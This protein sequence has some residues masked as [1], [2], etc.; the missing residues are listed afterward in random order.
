MRKVF[1]TIGIS[2]LVSCSVDH[3]MNQISSKPDGSMDVT[4]AEGTTGALAKNTKQS[5]KEV[6][7]IDGNVYNTVTI[8]KQEWMTENLKTTRLNDG[9]AIPLIT[10]TN[11]GLWDTTPGKPGYCWF[12]NDSV[13]NAKT[14]GALYNWYAVNTGKLAP[15]GWHVPSDSEWE[16]LGN[17]L[18]GDSVAGGPLKDT[19]TTYW[20]S[21]NTGATN[22]SGFSALPGGWRDDYGEFNGIGYGGIGYEGWWWSATAAD[23]IH[24][25][26]RGIFC[27]SA[28]VYRGNRNL[29]HNPLRSDVYG[30]SVRC[31]KGNPTPV[32]PSITMQ[33]QSQTVTAGQNVKFSVTATGY[34]PL[35]YQWYIGSTSISGATASSYSITNVQ[36]GNAGTYTVT[37]SN[38]TLPN[39][40]SNRAVLTV[41]PAPPSITT[42]PQSQTAMPGQNVKFSVVATGT[43][44]LSYQWYKDSIAIPGATSSSYS[45]SK[46]Q[47]SNAGTYTVTVSNGILPN[48]KSNG[49]ILT[50]SAAQPTVTDIDGN[51]YQP[52]T[53]GTQVWMAENLKT[54]RLNDGTAIPLVTNGNTWGADTTPGTPE[55]CWYNN[56]SATTGYC[57]N[58]NPDSVI[59]ANPCGALYNWYAVNTGK[60]APKGWHVPSDSEWEVLG[61]YLGGDSVA[62][63]P[64]KDTGT[65][66]WASPNTGAT[67]TSGFSALPG[68]WRDDYGEFNGIGYGGIGY[69][70]WWWSATAADSIHSWYRGILNNKSFVYRGNRNLTH[71]PERSDVYGFSVRCVKN[72]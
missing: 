57:G 46:V 9:T 54:T 48:A 19:G 49:A 33:P 69:E 60:L 59:C 27:S 71:N 43:A 29:T 23:S 6:I 12:H 20:A 51:V 63:G 24:S 4:K 1:L 32:A 11:G 50:V 7:D 65:T 39:A 31:V 28:S 62:G 37:V 34:G 30:F 70:G 15:K 17:Y 45:I 8:G 68:G 5:K 2:F 35:S 44:P 52:V 56:D 21:P 61:N 16:V 3:S 14:Y 58:I 36:A 10:W 41:N 40:K 64:L 22:T 13:Y 72:P 26:Y 66:Y 42:Q 47:S 18:G 55:Y 25:W 38:G 53:I 67:N